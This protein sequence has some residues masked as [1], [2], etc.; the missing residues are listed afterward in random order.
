MDLYL[1]HAYI[2]RGIET[3]NKD[4]ARLY[5]DEYAADITLTQDQIPEIYYQEIIK[6]TK[7][8][9]N[10]GIWQIFAFYSVLNRPIFSINR[11]L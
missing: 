7:D 1:S 3:T 11:N 6:P 4:L 5:F 10:M 9:S 2:G 8:K